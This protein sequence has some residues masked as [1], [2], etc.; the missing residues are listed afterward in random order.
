MYPPKQKANQYN[1]ISVSM[2][3]EDQSAERKFTKNPNRGAVKRA[4]KRDHMKNQSCIN[5]HFVAT[6][7]E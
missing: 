7:V 4:G 5:V 6:L 1:A 2:G 3:G